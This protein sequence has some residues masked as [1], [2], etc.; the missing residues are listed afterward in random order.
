M[1]IHIEIQSQSEPRFPQRMFIYHT[2][3][4]DRY[5]RPIASFAV[6][7]DE[8]PT[9]R[10]DRHFYDLW[11]CSVDFRF[12]IVKLL[13]LDEA[14]LEA[15]DNPF[16]VVIL[17]HLKTQQ[18]A[19]DAE[20][21]RSWKLRLIKGLYTRGWGRDQVRKLVRLIDWFLKLR[22][23]IESQVREEIRG[24]RDG[25]A[26]AVCHKFRKTGQRRRLQGRP[27]NRRARGEA[28]GLIFAIALGLEVKFGK[29]G[30]E[31]MPPIH[32][33]NDVDASGRSL[34]GQVGRDTR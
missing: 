5:S 12:P 20:R 21:R 4:F 30:L 34:N 32:H 6:L 18:T 15:S 7:A 16:A 24:V 10:P 29:P 13:E 9:W 17:A 23:E 19:D 33:L 31:L 3:L 11:G 22:K 8:S 28:T 1:L 25:E 26:D 27:S 2:C 14:F